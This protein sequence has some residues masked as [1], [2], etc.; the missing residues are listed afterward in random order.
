VLAVAI[1]SR[2]H[3]RAYDHRIQHAIAATGDTRLFA[4][5]RIP[6]ST[7]RT[8]ITRGPRHVVTLDS[9]EQPDVTLHAEFARLQHKHAIVVAIIGLLLALIRARA[10]ELD[11]GTRV[12]GAVSKR[13]LLRAIERARKVMPL[14]HAL[15]VLRISPARFHAWSAR[16]VRCALDDLPSCPRSRPTRTLAHERCAIQA[17]ALGDA[18]AHMSTRALALFAQRMGIV[19]ASPATW[20][21]LIRDRRWHRPRRR[22]H[23]LPPTEG[24]RADRPGQFLHVDVT[25]V[26]LLDGTRA[27]IQA[28]LDNY[29]RMILAYA[30]TT[31][32]DGS[33]TAAL[34]RKAAEA[35][36]RR[37]AVL[38]CDDGSENRG[39]EVDSALDDTGILQ[40]VSQVH[41]AFSNS[42]IEAFWRSLK[43]GFLH[44]HRLD[45]LATLQ[46]LVA[47]YVN[48]HN[49]VMPHS[50]FR[51]QTPQE[52]FFRTHSE[53][54][55]E[56]AAAHAN[57]R[58]ARL[59][60]NRRA[61][62]ALCPTAPPPFGLAP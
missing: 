54:P 37:T 46:R 7:A 16:D 62:C 45:S 40:L 1:P 36:H 21:R 27:F 12:P 57:A 2:R 8:W 31:S 15:R 6:D 28:I 26:R 9:C 58:A 4:R 13:R 33:L 59:E 53:L 24:I 49:T 30:V 42:M 47:F 19:F 35:L 32:Y 38:F 22:I 48:E 60:Q 25:S 41:I 51:G 5:L 61:Q 14:A 39:R 52:V 18:F 55:A 43:H 34:L 20:C 17:L 50:A 29:S 11:R 56:L 3:P 44:Q 23:P 10:I